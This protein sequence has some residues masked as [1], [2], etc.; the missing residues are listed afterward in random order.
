[1]IGSYLGIRRIRDRYDVRW[2]YNGQNLT[3]F[4]EDPFIENDFLR[5]NKILAPI[6]VRFGIKRGWIQGCAPNYILIW[7]CSCWAV[8][9]YS[10]N[11]KWSR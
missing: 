8:D 9:P 10:T 6:G 11:R 2:P 7:E 5:A 3:G 1:M 4:E